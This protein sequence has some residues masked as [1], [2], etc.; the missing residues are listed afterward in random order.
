MIQIA[1]GFQR[2]DVAFAV[3]VQVK[4]AAVDVG[5]EAGGGKCVLQGFTLLVV[6]VDVATGDGG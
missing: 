5:V 1:Q 2:A 3:G 6:H 4:A